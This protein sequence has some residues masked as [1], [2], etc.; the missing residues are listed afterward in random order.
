MKK[1]NT[2]WLSHL[3]NFFAV[4]LGVYLAFFIN[5]RAKRNQDKR[6]SLII[7]QSLVNDLS[8]DIKT[9]ETYQIPVNLQQTDDIEQLV[10]LLMTDS[11]EQVTGKLAAVMQL[12]NFAPTNSTYNSLMT[13]GRLGL[14]DDPSLQT[15]LTRFYEG[16]VVESNEKM[17]FQNEYFTNEILDWMVNNIDLME[18]KILNE[19]Q[20]ITFR[21]KLLIYHSLIEQKVASYQMVVDESKKLKQY[22]ELTIQP[23]K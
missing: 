8:G 4:I 11:I 21:N 3:F 20:L 15:M 10:H 1:K 14:I 12:E 22:L 16:V 9:Y 2:S 23:Q 17:K 19:N 18:L 13:S 7:M 6:E 5:E